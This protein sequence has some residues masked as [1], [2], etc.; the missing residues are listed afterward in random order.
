LDQAA[1]AHE[2]VERPVKPGRVLISIP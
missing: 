1:R 2:F